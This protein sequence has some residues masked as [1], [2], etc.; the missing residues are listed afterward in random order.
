MFYKEAALRTL[1][2]Y[3]EPSE[4]VIADLTESRE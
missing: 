2:A 1:D 4:R 3:L